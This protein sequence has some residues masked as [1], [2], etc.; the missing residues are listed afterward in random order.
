MRVKRYPAVL[1]LVVLIPILPFADASAEPLDLVAFARIT[2]TDTRDT[3][4]TLWPRESDDAP[5]TIRDGDLE[6]AWAVVEEGEQILTLDFAPLNP[7]APG[8]LWLVTRWAREPRTPV[9]VRI[10]E[11][12]GGPVLHEAIW[13][14]PSLPYVLDPPLPAR[15]VELI[16]RDAGRC[17]LAEM[18][19]FAAPAFEPPAV[20]EVSAY[21]LDDGVRLEWRI[22]NERVHH[23][24]I[25][26]LRD[27]AESP[28]PGSLIG[29]AP[30]AGPPAT[31]R[32]RP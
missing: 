20:R 16:L 17:A 21:P 31:A 19:V 23:V 15:C 29:R 28:S 25:H 14:D 8:L 10:S 24:E 6:T 4:F 9:M 13:P 1:F 7:V 18:H 5:Y 26:Y 30:A 2:A 32:P 12:C 27:A 3:F 11:T 22:E